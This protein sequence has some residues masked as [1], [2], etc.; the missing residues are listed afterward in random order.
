MT[1]SFEREG[2]WVELN[3]FS[4]NEVIEYLALKL[5]I[6]KPRFK[7]SAKPKFCNGVMVKFDDVNFIIYADKTW[8][9]LSF[10]QANAEKMSPVIEEITKWDKFS[11]TE[12]TFYVEIDENSSRTIIFENGYA[13]CG[14][15]RRRFGDKIKITSFKNNN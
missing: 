9:E 14:D 1:I 8:I 12:K 2:R 7:F 4:N 3:E 10:E 11:K 5:N 6:N 15:Y 13:T